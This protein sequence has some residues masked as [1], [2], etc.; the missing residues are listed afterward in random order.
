MAPFEIIIILVAIGFIVIWIRTLLEISKSEFRGNEKII[1]MLVVFLFGL[2][3]LVT[4]YAA[5]RNSR[6][7][8]SD[9]DDILD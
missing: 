3:G 1:W 2:I 4:Y 9:S 6:I 7:E 5:G 8:S